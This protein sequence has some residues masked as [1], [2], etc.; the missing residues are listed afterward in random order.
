MLFFATLSV[1]AQMPAD[2][3]NPG[4]GDLITPVNVRPIPI[5]E[6]LQRRAAPT[7]PAAR[8]LVLIQIESL[9]AAVLALG[10]A[11]H[12]D[13][14][15]GWV[16][17]SWP[18]VGRMSQLGPAG[19]VLRPEVAAT[20]RATGRLGG[21]H[22]LSQTAAGAPM[23]TLSEVA[24][25]QE[26][27]AAFLTDGDPGE[28]P[29]AAFFV[30]AA[31]QDPSS[32]QA[33][34]ERLKPAVLVCGA[35]ARS[36]Q[37][38]SASG[39]LSLTAQPPVPQAGQEKEPWW[40]LPASD[41]VPLARLWDETYRH[42]GTHHERFFLVVTVAGVRQALATADPRRIEQALGEVNQLFGRVRDAVQSRDDMVAVVVPVGPAS[43]LSILPA[44][45]RA[46]FRR[47]AASTADLAGAWPV[48]GSG[49]AGSGSASLP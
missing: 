41:T 33:P 1:L 45:S 14:P 37:V 47:H 49:R 30:H 27:S 23:P 36:L 31:P 18:M 22:H 2:Q 3:P 35:A 7:G 44:F 43:G 40:W 15:G 10:Q 4:P 28:S 13:R 29:L 42:L 21:A 6:A 8:R 19:E 25:S 11:L 12:G 48:D 38:P 9:D 46:H 24:V 39:S 16:L 20:L 5:D 34:L 26:M 17:D 32:V